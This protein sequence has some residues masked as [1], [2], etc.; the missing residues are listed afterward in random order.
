MCHN[1]DFVKWVYLVIEIVGAFI[2]AQDYSCTNLDDQLFHVNQTSFKY[3][4]LRSNLCMFLCRSKNHTHTLISLGTEDPSSKEGMLWLLEYGFIID[5]K[6][7]P[8]GWFWRRPGTKIQIPFYQYT[9]RIEYWS[10]IRCEETE[11]VIIII[12]DKERLNM[13]HIIRAF[14][15]F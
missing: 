12:L 1:A 11:S 14:N 9:S 13:K 5:L 7:D 8:N 2:V 15:W 6:W 3:P 10:I 4:S